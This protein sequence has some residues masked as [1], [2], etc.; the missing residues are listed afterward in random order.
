MTFCVHV[1]S[2][3][4]TLYMCILDFFKSQYSERKPL[5]LD[6]LLLSVYD[7]KAEEVI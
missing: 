1:H 6:T 2:I 4:N 7:E 3:P 5:K